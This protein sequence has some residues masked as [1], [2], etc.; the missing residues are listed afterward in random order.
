M[1]M[2][3]HLLLKNHPC[4]TDALSRSSFLMERNLIFFLLFH[5]YGV[6]LCDKRGIKSDLDSE[7]RRYILFYM[8]DEILQHFISTKHFPPRTVFSQNHEYVLEATGDEKD[9]KDKS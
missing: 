5:S 7:R 9:E 1:F 8:E 4:A 2:D 6:K 3:M